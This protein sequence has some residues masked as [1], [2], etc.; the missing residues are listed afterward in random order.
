MRAVFLLLLLANLAFF[1]WTHYLAPRAPG[2]DTRPLTRQIDPGA[3]RIL[4][5]A[6]LAALTSP[7]KSAAAANQPA[8]EKP[9]P[10]P[11][12]APPAPAACLEWGAFDAADAARAAQALAPLALGARLTQRRSGETVAWWV[13]IPPQGSAAEA[14]KKASEL[15]ALGVQHYFIVQDH[16]AQ[17]WAISL[18]VFRNE[19]AAETRLRELQAK[20]VHSAKLGPYATQNEK[21][22]YQVHDADA[23]LQSKL[24]RLAEQF[25]GS[26][27]QACAAPTAQTGAP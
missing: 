4:S 10:A 15:K 20:K 24:A 2:T 21:L 13:F 19:P 23:A 17:R 3:I 14:Q 6:E 27:L 9:A 1:A 7:P 8:P 26:A 16:G 12:A 25:P 11:A 22:W 18:G 5:S